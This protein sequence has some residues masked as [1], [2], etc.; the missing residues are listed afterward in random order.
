VIT[1]F[2]KKL[3]YEKV[4]NKIVVEKDYGMFLCPGSTVV[5]QL[6]HNPQIT[7]LEPA[8]E[9]MAVKIF[10]D[11]WLYPGSPV[12]EHLPHKPEIKDSKPAIEKTVVEKFK[13]HGCTL[14]AQW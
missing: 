10:Y 9:K 1:N 3:C 6:T 5:E 13:V 8:R 14:V 4:T 12:V 2:L 7:S 11:M